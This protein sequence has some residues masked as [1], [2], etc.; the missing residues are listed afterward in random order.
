[1]TVGEALGEIDGA[2]TGK[3]TGRIAGR[4]ADF[5][6]GDVTAGDGFAT[7]LN[8]SKTNKKTRK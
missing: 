6:V 3:I 5:T 7:L 8:K 1:M 4:P 2:E